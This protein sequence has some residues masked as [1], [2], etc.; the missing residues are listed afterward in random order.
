MSLPPG[1]VTEAEVAAFQELAYREYGVRLTDQQAY[2]Q[3]AAL[4]TLFETLLKNHLA[5]GHQNDMITGK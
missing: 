2:E 1:Y 4:L 3:A 5:F